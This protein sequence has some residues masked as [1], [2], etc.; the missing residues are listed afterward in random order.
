MMIQHHDGLTH[1]EQL[2]A[3]GNTWLIHIYNDK[4]RITAGKL[5]C[6]LV[7][8]NLPLRI[9]LMMSEV[10]HHRLHGGTDFIKN[11][12]CLTPQR[13][14][15]P[16]NPNSCAKAVHIRDTV[17]HNEY[18]FLAGNNFTESLRLHTSLDTGIL[19]YLLALATVI[20][21]R[22]W[23]FDYSLVSASPKCKVDCCSCILTVLR[24]SRR[25]QTHTDACRYCH[26]ISDIYSLDFFQNIK[27]G[28]LHG[29]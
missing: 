29:K 23:C 26:F 18:I 20:Y 3:L 17:S 22:L 25:I 12:M 6:L 19:L 10:I 14:C 13:T 5:H 7:A 2:R 8:D 16:V 11:N 1:P 24:I 27:S 15:H 21:N 28:F 9:I 4:H